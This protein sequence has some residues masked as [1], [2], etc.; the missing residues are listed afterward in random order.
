M[1]NEPQL[2]TGQSSVNRKNGFNQNDFLVPQLL[3]QGVYAYVYIYVFIDL[4]LHTFKCPL[5]FN[6]QA[7][8]QGCKSENPQYLLLRKFQLIHRNR[9]SIKPFLDEQRRAS[10]RRQGFDQRIKTTVVIQIVKG[11]EVVLGRERSMHEGFGQ[12]KHIEPW[13]PKYH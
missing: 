5:C 4:S 10:E 9:L 12:G 2:P 3:I 8:P 11:L 1:Q 6:H 7:R 13:K